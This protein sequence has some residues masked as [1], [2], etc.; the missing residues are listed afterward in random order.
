LPQESS[1][2]YRH[3]PASRTL[4]LEVR[5]GR[6]VMFAL[7]LLGFLMVGW[8][9]SFWMSHATADIMH[10]MRDPTA[11]AT[12]AITSSAPSYVDHE[13]VPLTLPVLYDAFLGTGPKISIRHAGG[14]WEPMLCLVLAAGAFLLPR[15]V[16]QSATLVLDE[17]EDRL[18]LHQVR[19]GVPDHATYPLSTLAEAVL[20]RR[21]STSL[22]HLVFVNG[23]RVEISAS[24]GDTVPERLVS[25]VNRFIDRRA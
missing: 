1:S 24:A 5:Q 21:G 13:V 8:A 10:V 12:E 3:K 19:F 22:G 9:V 16:R 6:T 23:E 15:F 17:R 25:T 11:N 2:A 7:I 4:V 20:V 14:P 18:T